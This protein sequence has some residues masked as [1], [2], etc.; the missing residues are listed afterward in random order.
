MGI[1]AAKKLTEGFLW[2]W[3]KEFIFIDEEKARTHYRK[4]AAGKYCGRA[5]D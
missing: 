5:G 1:F 2:N 4:C 3:I